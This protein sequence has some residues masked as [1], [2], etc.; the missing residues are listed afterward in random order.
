MRTMIA[1]IV[2]KCGVGNSMAMLVP[3]AGNEAAYRAWAPLLLANLCSMAF[4]FALRQKVQGQN[5]TGS[6]LSSP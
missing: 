5:L 3:E 1:A 4:D 6:S 2:P